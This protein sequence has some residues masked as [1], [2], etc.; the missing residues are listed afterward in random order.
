[1]IKSNKS[2]LY[3]LVFFH[4]IFRRQYHFGS[5]DKSETSSSRLG[6]TTMHIFL[7]LL[8]RSFPSQ[9]IS[10]CLPSNGVSPRHSPV[11]CFSVL[12]NFP[13]FSRHAFCVCLSVWPCFR[14]VSGVLCGGLALTWEKKKKKKKLE[15]EE[16]M[17]LAGL[18]RA[19]L[20]PCPNV[21]TI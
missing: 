7:L 4:F 15:G 14:F 11:D 6:T 10:L 12:R 19:C 21:R 20:N 13:R 2:Q 16:K 18:L 5:E 3:Q 17:T 1:M 8:L 9:D